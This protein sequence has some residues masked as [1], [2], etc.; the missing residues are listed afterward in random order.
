MLHRQS[1]GIALE[2]G[3][4]VGKIEVV[5]F[6][7]FLGFI[8]LIL[9]GP[10]FGLDLLVSRCQKARVGWRESVFIPEPQV[11]GVCQQS[12]LLLR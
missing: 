11:I 3:K 6:D 1:G 12:P 9:V 4:H 5:V 7:F 8:G 2:T 10:E